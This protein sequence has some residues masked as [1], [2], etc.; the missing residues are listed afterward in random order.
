M[1]LKGLKSHHHLLLEKKFLLI[2]LL[3]IIPNR[4]DKSVP[5]NHHLG[6][7]NSI[8]IHLSANTVPGGREVKR[9]ANASEGVGFDPM[10]EPVIS[11]E[12]CMCH[13]SQ[14]LQVCSRLV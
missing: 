3:R 11:L 9:D 14:W 13:G 1:N 7:S 8:M 2:K 5:R 10:H 4:T 6:T 12:L